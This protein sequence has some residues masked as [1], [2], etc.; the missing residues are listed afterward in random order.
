MKM[1]RL[2]AFSTLTACVLA[3]GCALEEIAACN[4]ACQWMDSCID[5]DVNID[6]CTERCVDAVEKSK[7]LRDDAESCAECTEDF[8]CKDA[9]TSCAS[10]CKPVMV[11]SE[12]K[13]DYPDD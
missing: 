6:E 1:V 9:L 4:T 13:L 8:A 7:S 10:S 12:P 11:K 3:G 2:L 5:R